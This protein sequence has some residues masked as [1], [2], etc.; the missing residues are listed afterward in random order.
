VTDLLVANALVVDGTGARPFRGS[1]AVSADRI[2][3]VLRDGEDEP[4][5][6]RRF[7]A[8]GRVVAPGSIDA[9]SHSDVEPFVEP[10][11]DSML[12]QGV[13]TMVVGNCGSS[14]W[15]VEGASELAEWAGVHGLDLDLSWRTFGEY[16]EAVDAA[17][18]ALNIAA[19]VGHG[20][21]RLAV[22]RNEQRRSP[23]GEEM[24]RMR[25]LLASA[26]TEGA[27]GLSSGLIYAPGIHATTE[28]IAEIASVMA[29]RGGLY[30]SHIRD[31]GAHV[32]DALAEC[33]R[34]GRLAGVGSHVSHLKV[35]T[36]FAWGR[37]QELLD[38]I[39]EEREAGADV[40][41]DQYPY[42]AWETE[43][44]S[45]LPPWASPEELPDLRA[46]PET[47]ERL[48]R[49][50]EEGEEGWE[51]SVA[52]VGWDRSVIAAHAGAPE[53]SGRSLEELARKRSTAPVE[54]LLDLLVAD[55]HT[56]VIGH[57]MQEDDVRLIAARP[58]VFVGSDGLAVTPGGPL[59]RFNVHPRY[60]GTFPRVLRRY[61][62]EDPVLSLEEAVRK[63]TSLPADRF[64]LRDRGRIDV[65][66]FADLV[67]F[68]PETVADRATFEAPH[69]FA[70]GIDLVVVNGRVAWDGRRGERAGRAL[71]RG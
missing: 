67:V 20:T 53:L 23:S 69:A 21:L 64:G 1:V 66:G 38:L 35:S 49:S 61:V 46:D 31:E 11:M 9:H 17:S 59:G 5:A 30:A 50:I 54:V 55:P 42:T 32:L 43:L 24:E 71:R 15:P 56:G 26:I 10:G 68:D 41:A 60:Y 51:S 63:M 48:R 45:Y 44:A 8:E 2:E 62:R 12:R 34:I 14:A 57:G 28:E 25:T 3:R 7:D 40:T 65:G 36:S 29:G 70:E 18:P 58:D 39:D 13:T 27:I 6:A 22:L 16:L 52:G 37:A 19:L 33:I 47:A 4:I